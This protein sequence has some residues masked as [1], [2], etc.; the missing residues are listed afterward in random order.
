MPVRAMEIRQMIG[1]AGRPGYDPHG[2][3][4]ILAKNSN[5]EQFIV[6]RYLL[7]GVEPIVSRLA[8]PYSTVATEDP[9]LLTHLLALI[10]TGGI[11]DRY[12]LGMFL[13]KTFLG[14]TISKEDLEAKIDRSIV[15]LF[16][17][18]MITREGD[19]EK[20]TKKIKEF[21]FIKMLGF[22]WVSLT[23]R[24]LSTIRFTILRLEFIYLFLMAKWR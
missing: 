23:K 12:S 5:E 13:A 20:L 9:S 19:D 10:A 1:R 7:G 15:W 21:G 11:Q 17:N 22:L 18:D 14:A 24:K 6:D 8:N 16:E 2:E 4:I 3:G